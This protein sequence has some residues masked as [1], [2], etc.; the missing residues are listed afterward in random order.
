VTTQTGWPHD[1][2][3]EELYAEAHAN[4]KPHY[5]VWSQYGDEPVATCT[6]LTEARK[7]IVV[8]ANLWRHELHAHVTG[9]A[10]SGQYTI[11]WSKDS[12]GSWG[13][14]IDTCDNPEC[15]EEY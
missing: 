9:S 11:K 14:W 1:A 8:E 12:Y 10:R 7:A 13:L 2:T 3:P 5:H 4:D 6:T 15:L